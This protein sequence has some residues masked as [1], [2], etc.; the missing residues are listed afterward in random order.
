L[1]QTG[2]ESLYFST[3]CNT[4][5]GQP[6][7]EALGALSAYLGGKL[8]SE[9][10]GR[11]NFPPRGHEFLNKALLFRLTLTRRFEEPE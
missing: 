3:I 8:D 5:T 10:N 4:G 2:S 9:F 6:I 11:L 1:P 7:G